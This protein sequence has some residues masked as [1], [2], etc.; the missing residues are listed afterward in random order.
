MAAIQRN[1]STVQHLTGEGFTAKQSWK[2]HSWYCEAAPFALQGD[3][4][5]L[6]AL[7]RFAAFKT[8]WEQITGGSGPYSAS[9][10]EVPF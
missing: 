10:D 3:E 5:H 4:S 8:R 2:D 7:E 1:G 6:D 9:E